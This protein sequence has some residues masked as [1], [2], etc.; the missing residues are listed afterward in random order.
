MNLDQLKSKILE[1]I[2]K[3]EITFLK[4]LDSKITIDK[5]GKFFFFE[6]PEL[7]MSNLSRFLQDLFISY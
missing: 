3:N 4:E 6:C 2:S 7:T 1:V 5:R